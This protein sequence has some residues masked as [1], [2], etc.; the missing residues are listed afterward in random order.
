MINLIEILHRVSNRLLDIQE[1]KQIYQIMHEGMVDILPNVYSIVTK[2][3]SNDTNFRVIH[4]FGFEKYIN[5][6]KKLI[7]KDPFEIDYPI[8][9]FSEQKKKE[10]ETRNLFHFSDGIYGVT[11]GRINK[12]ICKT[13]EK[14]LG[15]SEIYAISFCIGKKYFGGAIIFIPKSTPDAKNLP[16]DTIH[17]IESIASQTSFAICRFRDYEELLRKEN[18]LLISQSRYNQIINQLNDIVWRANGDGTGIIDVNSSFEKVFGYSESEFVKNP[19][20]LFSMVH[21]EDKLIA[22]KSKL[23]LVREGHSDCEYRIV[24]PDGKIIWL[25]DRR[26]IIL[27]KIG[28]PLQMGG[29]FSDITEKK[30][31]ENNLKNNEAILSKSIK[32]KDKF[33]AII[34]HDLKS[35]FN[36]ML[37]LLGILSKE[38]YDLS[39][40]KRFKMI[41]SSLGSAQKAYSLLLDLLEWARHQ[42]NT[43]VIKEESID[44]NKIINETIE[45]YAT[46]VKIKEISIKNNVKHVTTVN[47]DLNSIK[48][49]IRNIYINAIKFTPNR[50][51]IVFKINQIKEN[52]EI[53]IKDTGVGMSKDTLNKL[54]KLDEDTTMPGT[55]NEK[56]TGLG[57]IICNEIAIKNNWKI[58]VLSEL[59][60]GSEFKILIPHKVKLTILK[61]K[62]Y[63]SHIN[64]N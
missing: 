25:H 63:I 4:S 5:I 13:I 61:P 20:L 59:K 42:N 23:E 28:N 9:D 30:I 64:N 41:S 55:N 37:G 53:S 35:P 43:V 17:A 16:K 36:G 38:Y 24:R 50:G 14:I 6:F 21:E 46:N 19:D 8:S 22:K 56:G 44:L 39:D 32:E 40:E 2:F 47:I 26:S 45:L 58:K 1:E 18:E 60:K 27:D 48:T 12:T 62:Q 11:N 3:T 34:A 51:S 52:I 49:I 54:F 7:G 10:Y 57:L 29:L 31:L 33:F 15:I